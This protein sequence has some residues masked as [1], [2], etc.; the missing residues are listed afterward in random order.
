[1]GLCHFVV[2]FFDWIWINGYVYSGISRCQDLWVSFFKIIKGYIHFFLFLDLQ[3]C[4]LTFSGSMGGIFD[5]LMAQPCT[6]EP[7]MTPTPR[8]DFSLP[9]VLVVETVGF[10]QL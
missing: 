7:E 9:I 8:N 2:P 6:L 1:M 3:V 10:H 5:F 4:F